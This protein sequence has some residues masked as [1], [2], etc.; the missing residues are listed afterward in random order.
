M[1][2]AMLPMQR[3]H[4]VWIDPDDNWFTQNVK[5][6]GAGFD[7]K[8]LGSKPGQLARKFSRL[9]GKYGEWAVGNRTVVEEWISRMA[10]AHAATFGGP[11][12]HVLDLACGI[13]LPGLRDT[14]ETGHF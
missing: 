12:V 6:F 2:F 1:Y 11:A 14:L 4:G 13:G 7:M 10:R 5:R 3:A 8:E 9:S